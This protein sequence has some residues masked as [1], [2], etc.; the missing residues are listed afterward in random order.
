MNSSV[1]TPK[2]EWRRY[3]TLA[4]ASAIGYSITSIH[5]YSL[6]AFIEPLQQEFGWSRSQISVGLTIS[7]LVSVGL[8]IP[9]GM[10]VDRFGPRALGLMGITLISTAYALLGT[11]TGTIANWISLWVIFAVVNVLM[12]A[13]VWTKAVASCFVRARGSAF[14][15]TLCGSAIGATVFPLLATWLIGTLG[16]RMAFP[17]LAGMWAA[18]ILPIVLLYFRVPKKQVTH[19]GMSEPDPEFAISGVTLKQALRISAFYKL[20]VAAALFV[21]SITGNVVHFVPL[22][23]DLGADPLSAAG[24]ASI[25]GVFSIIGRLSTGPLLDV[26]R[27][28]IVGAGVFLL[29]IIASTLLLFSGASAANQVIAAACI[30]FTLGSEVDVIAYLTSRYLGVRHFGA[31]FGAMSA[32]LA[33]GSAFGPLAAGAVFDTF[34]NYVPFMVTTVAA[35]LMSLLA[36]ASLGRPKF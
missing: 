21:F 7:G 22:L 9:V 24:V 15:L 29:P 17:A 11:A 5:V 31:L 23:T 6:G 12:Q 2:Q 26:F 34:G 32:A 1:M 36:L 13:T 3:W 14:A 25:I 27:A 33:L 20:L 16:W 10:L 35:S 30:G 19:T 8:A 28:N 4:V 18:L